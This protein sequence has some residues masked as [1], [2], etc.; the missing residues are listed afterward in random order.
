M[1]ITGFGSGILTGGKV[2]SERVTLKVWKENKS[3][4]PSSYKGN[5]TA[6][7]DV[8]VISK[9]TAT[10]EELDSIQ[11]N[12]EELDWFIVHGTVTVT[13]ID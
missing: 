8:I 3:A 5:D 9:P 6:T 10:N 4:P 7:F 1:T 13:F 2:S 12:T 11:G